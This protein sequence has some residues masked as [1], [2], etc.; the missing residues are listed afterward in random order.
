MQN[1]IKV[2]LQ[3]PVVAGLEWVTFEEASYYNL[4]LLKREKGEIKILDQALRL[5]S[6]TRVQ[7]KLGDHIPC[8]LV[9]NIRGII[10]RKLPATNSNS[11][12]IL[13]SVFPNAS[14]EDFYLQK[15]KIANGCFASVVRRTMIDQL[16]IDFEAANLWL[17]SVRLGSFDVKYLRPFIQEPAVLHTTTQSLFFDAAQQ[18]V[19]VEKYIPTSNETQYIRIEEERLDCQ[20]LVAFAVSFKALMNQPS[21][22]LSIPAIQQN[23]AELFHKNLFQKAGWTLLLGTLVLLLFNLLFYYQF[24]EKNDALGA[25]MIYTNN[26]LQ[27]LDSLQNKV[28][29]QKEFLQKT[30]LNQNSKS[31]Y[32]ADRIAASLLEGL[33]LSELEI[34]PI[35]GK[36][37]DY[38]MQDLIHYNKEEV[39][40]KGYCKNSSS[41]NRWIKVLQN[42]DWVADIQHL[43]YKDINNELGAFEL[44][45]VISF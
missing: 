24:K 6:L 34:F 40:I 31:S 2:A 35:K 30:Q 37:E 38:K 39:F 8:H 27:T 12:Q 18:L 33:Q 42:F 25:Q 7:E 45:L 13:Q 28:D 14:L 9:A 43:D 20:L 44:K 22:G 5:T 11:Q 17:L 32:L 41:Y 16:V 1:R 19:D 10:H 29:R 23:A 15:E 3:S 4:V 21:Q 26:Q 36:S